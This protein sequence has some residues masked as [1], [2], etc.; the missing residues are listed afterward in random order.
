M[1]RGSI[2]PRIGLVELPMEKVVPVVS[3][4]APVISITLALIRWVDAFRLSSQVE[5]PLPLP[6]RVLLAR[7]NLLVLSTYIYRGILAAKNPP[8]REG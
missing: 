6:V 8:R 4:V 7:Y 5:M 2:Y 1:Q 3:A